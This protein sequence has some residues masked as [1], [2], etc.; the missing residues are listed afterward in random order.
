MTTKIENEVKEVDQDKCARALERLLACFNQEQLTNKEIVLMHCIGRYPAPLDEL[1]LNVINDLRKRFPEAIIGYSDHSLDP[2]TAPVAAVGLGAKVIEKHITLDRNLSDNDNYCAIEPKELSAM[3]GAIRRTE[4]EMRV[5]KKIEV[6]P[7][8]LG[9]SQKKTLEGEEYIR[10]FAYRC[11]F[12]VKE[13]K[14][15][16]LFTN[17]NIAVLRPGNVERGVEPKYYELLINGNRA[18]K[19]IKKGEPIKKGYYEN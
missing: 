19:N 17:D 5:G 7:S 10:N 1:N 14:I 15:G 18:L 13:I 8:V 4:R 9:S 6:D 12:A 11:I 16:E 2:I 3:V